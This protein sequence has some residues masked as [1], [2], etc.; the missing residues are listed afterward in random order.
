MKNCPSILQCLQFVCCTSS[1]VADQYSLFFF[2]RKCFCFLCTCEVAF[3]FFL[4]L[5]SYWYCL[6]CIVCFNWVLW[7][8]YSRSPSESPERRFKKKKRRKNRSPSIESS[9]DD[10]DSETD[11][12][13]YALRAPTQNSVKLVTR[14]HPKV[15]TFVHGLQVVH[16]L[17][18]VR[19]K[20]ERQ[21]SK[22]NE[23]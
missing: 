3:N 15:E 13:R 22:P 12:D 7:L 18:D 8:F 5:L 20:V 23:S 14:G 4:P 10:S 11:S 1:D 17:D 2:L 21:K 16:V 6:P 9:S 19:H